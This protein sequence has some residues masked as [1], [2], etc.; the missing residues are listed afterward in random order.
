MI[1]EV[2]RQLPS[3]GVSGL[4]FVMWWFERADRTRFAAGMK[5]SHESLSQIARINEQ[6][7]GVIRSNTAAMTSLQDELRA[8]RASE[9][10]WLKRLSRQVETLDN[11]QG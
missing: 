7:L 1:D 6:L 11:K 5:E 4:L 9:L 8:H 3:L 2:M 10:E